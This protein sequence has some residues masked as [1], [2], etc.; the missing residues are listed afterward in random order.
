MKGG[1]LALGGGRRGQ[2]QGEGV[3]SQHDLLITRLFGC[4]D[5]AVLRQMGWCRHHP[6]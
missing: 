1:S 5:S 3:R 2:V 6:E 4:R